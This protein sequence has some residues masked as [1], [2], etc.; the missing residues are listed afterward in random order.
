MIRPMSGLDRTVLVI[1]RHNQPREGMAALSDF[2]SGHYPI[3][4][5]HCLGAVILDKGNVARQ[6][7]QIE[8]GP[9]S[10]CNCA[11]RVHCARER[12]LAR[13]LAGPAREGGQPSTVPARACTYSKQYRHAQGRERK[14][15]NVVFG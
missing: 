9:F 15:S 11:G 10:P 1:S 3:P 4:A 13:Y 12:P 7:G 2:G 14:K 8:G 6:S 5:P